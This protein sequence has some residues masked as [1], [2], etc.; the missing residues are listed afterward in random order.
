MAISSTCRKVYAPD[1]GQRAV[2][3]HKAMI[4]GY[5]NMLMIDVEEL[6]VPHPSNITTWNHSRLPPV[7]LLDYMDNTYKNG[8]AYCF[9]DL[10][11]PAPSPP[12][13]H[14][15]PLKWAELL[16]LHRLVH[17]PPVYAVAKCIYKPYRMRMM[18][19]H[20][21]RS[22]SKDFMTVFEKP[23]MA[24]KHHYRDESRYKLNHTMQ[25]TVPEE[26]KSLLLGSSTYQELVKEL[27][28]LD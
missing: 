10:T 27:S 17:A 3:I 22:W 16:Y 7:N 5:E 9:W 20:A 11:F 25:Y 21:G 8:S 13:H 4:D 6:I 23:H 1:T 14:K 26:F 19:V 18:C 28:R 15:I 2:Y 12:V 24:L